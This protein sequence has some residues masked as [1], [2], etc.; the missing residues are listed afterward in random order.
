MQKAI[1]RWILIGIAVLLVGPVVGWFFRLIPSIDGGSG[2]TPLVSLSAP[3]GIGFGV[4]GLLL[5]GA[6]GFLAARLVGYRDGLVCMG[7]AFAW[8]CWSTGSVTD[9]VR[10]TGSVPVFRLAAE[11]A[12][13]GLVAAGLAVL[14]VRLARDHDEPMAGDAP[15]ASVSSLVAIATAALG[16]LVAGWVVARSELVGQTL[17]AAIAGGVLGGVLARVAQPN[18]SAAATTIGVPIVAAVGI[19]VGE[20]LT[21]GGNLAQAIYAGAT[22]PL[23]RIMPIDWIAG[24]LLGLPI[25]ISWGGS[26]VERHVHE[27]PG[28]PAGIASPGA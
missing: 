28:K 7:L 1:L 17:W 13:L 8:A 21:T 16:A 23:M 12:I 22:T 27:G 25:G 2:V 24:M 20:A 14:I 18:C 4:A 9:L 5:A 26:L 15:L 19:L 11:G 6:I 3:A 10:V